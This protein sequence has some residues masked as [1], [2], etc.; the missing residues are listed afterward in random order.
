TLDFLLEAQR[1]W[2]DALRAEYQAIADYNNAMA[3]FEYAKGTIMQRDNIVIAEGG[4]PQ[5][6]QVRAVE[7]ERERSSALVLRE[8]AKPVTV[9][10]CRVEGGTLM[11][12]PEL[13]PSSAPSVPALF[14]GQASLDKVPEHLPA[15]PGAAGGQGAG[16]TAQDPARQESRPPE[17]ASAESG[18]SSLR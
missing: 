7:H 16:G 1:L 9:P 4:L 5:C 17:S 8:R 15:V 6:A 13:P 2:A 3:R 12:L 10:C 11:G 14:E 18:S